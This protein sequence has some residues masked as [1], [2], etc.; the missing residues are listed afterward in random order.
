MLL[1]NILQ[2]KHDWRRTVFIAVLI[3]NPVIKNNLTLTG[4]ICL[5]WTVFLQTGWS[6]F[7]GS[8]MWHWYDTESL[9]HPNCAAEDSF[10]LEEKKCG[11]MDWNACYWV[12]FCTC[13]HR[14][15]VRKGTQLQ[16]DDFTWNRTRAEIDH[17]D[18]G[19]LTLEVQVTYTQWLPPLVGTALATCRRPGFV[20]SSGTDFSA[21][22]EMSC[23]FA[24]MTY[25]ICNM[26]VISM[27]AKFWLGREWQVGTEYVGVA[28]PSGTILCK[29]L[30]A[31]WDTN[32]EELSAFWCLFPSI[33]DPASGPWSSFVNH[34]KIWCLKCI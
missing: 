24:Y 23:C 33:A 34:L 31:P 17:Q 14:H 15:M 29:A 5:H 16:D 19:S 6:Q 8:G 21:P 28:F 27:E 26:G 20:P 12:S 3:L 13:V 9:Q 22:F 30:A 10:L 4:H 25:P 18:F 1:R 2:S 32:A 7:I 11:I